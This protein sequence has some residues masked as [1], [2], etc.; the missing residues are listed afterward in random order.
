MHGVAGEELAISDGGPDKEHSGRDARILPL[1]VM[2]DPSSPSSGTTLHDTKRTTLWLSM[3]HMAMKE[4]VC[5]P[6]TIRKNQV[7]IP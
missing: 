4:F 1:V 3:A 7:D 6:D 5:V 2:E